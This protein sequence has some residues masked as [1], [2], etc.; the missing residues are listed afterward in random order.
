V[1]TLLGIVVVVETPATA[2]PVGPGPSA[3]ANASPGGS[4]RSSEAALPNGATPSTTIA[5]GTSPSPT[6]RPTVGPTATPQANTEPGIRIGVMSRPSSINPLTARTQA[7]RD[8]V[9]LVFSGLLRLGGDNELAADLA[10]RWK[11]ENGGARYT[12]T[13]RD[14]ARWH[15]G[16]EVTADDVVFTIQLMQDPDYMGPRA[17][18]WSDVTVTKLNDKMVQFD[19][20]TPLGGFLTNLRQ[21]LLP[22]HLLHDVPVRELA[23]SPFSTAPVGSGPYRLVAW[24]PVGARLEP[25]RWADP[26]ESPSGEPRPAPSASGADEDGPVPVELRFFGS[27]V[28]LT[29]AYRAGDLDIA[30]GLP[31]AAAEA[32]AETEG[33]RLLRYPRATVTAIALNLRPGYEPV[34]DEVVRRALLRILDR[35]TMIDEIASGVAVRADGLIPPTSWAFSKPDNKAIV[36]DRN[37]AA[38][39]LQQAGW[40]K[41]D[42]RWYPKGSDKP[43]ELELISPDAESNPIV[44]A[45]AQEIARQWTSFGISTTVLPLSPSVFVGDRLSKARFEAAVVDI[46]VGLDP[47]LYPLLGSRQAGVGGSNIS[48]YQD[49]ELDER[50]AEA[51]KPGD[52]AARMKAYAAVQAYL[53][54][55]QPMLPLYWRDEP[56]VLSDRVVGPAKHLLGD[57]S[58]RFW[59]VLDWRLAPDQ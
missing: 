46:N 21:P 58:D 17:G 55:A 51:R 5:P 38:A 12:L 48:G 25:V 26:D 42:G 6:P 1:L 32:L 44:L 14:D 43:Y 40:R 41:R 45:T 7:D 54:T 56:V 23:D 2:G 57:P 34:R 49:L 13:I 35:P 18:S 31:A 24:D 22:E 11:I 27:P 59:D 36:F 9:S 33:S 29:E 15:D 20:Q 53:S 50:L 4:P 28:S 47:D 3:A 37:G 39:E 8:L 19:L 10:S 16:I 30:F 52:D